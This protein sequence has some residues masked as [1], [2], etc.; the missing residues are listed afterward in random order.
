MRGTVDLP[1]IAAGGVLGRRDVVKLID[2]GAAS[3]ACGSAF[4]LA[5]EA[6]TSRANREAMRGGGVSV[7]SRAFS[8]RWARGLE[9]EFTRSHPNMPAIYPYLKPMVPDNL[10]CL[11]WADFEGIAQAPAARIEAALTP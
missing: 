11:V 8:G 6:G 3:V 1:V 5:E 4:L 2:A 7:S 10:Y 9:T